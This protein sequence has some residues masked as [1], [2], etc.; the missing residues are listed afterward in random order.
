MSYALPTFNI[1]CNI[2]RHANRPPGPGPD[3]SNV[4]CN[5]AI[6]RRGVQWNLEQEYPGLIDFEQWVN[7]YLLLPKAIDI[8]GVNSNT[9]FD[10]VEVPAGSGIYYST[11]YVYNAATGFSNQ[12]RVAII[13][14]TTPYIDPLPS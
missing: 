5:L 7:C 14:Q 11:R 1:V 3:F 6:G 4:P 9:P 2:W 13:N 12:H 8:R 10:W